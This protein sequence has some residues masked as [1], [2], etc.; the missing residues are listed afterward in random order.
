MAIGN[1]GLPQY[2]DRM[3][4]AQEYVTGNPAAPGELEHN[5]H[6]PVNAANV[7]YVCTMANNVW[8]FDADGGAPI[9]PQPVSLGRPGTVC[10]GP[11]SR[12]RRRWSGTGPA[13]RRGR[14]SGS[15]KRPDW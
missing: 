3:I 15:W 13:S 6:G 12:P 10:G 2:G 9:W 14:P 7:V 4:L 1:T 5:Q 11:R 8:A